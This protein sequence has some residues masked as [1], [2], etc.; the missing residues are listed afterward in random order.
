MAAGL[1]DGL[2]ECL[3]GELELGHQA[4]VALGLVHCVEVLAL[5]VLYQSDRSGL[6]VGHLVDESGD[7]VKTGRTGRSPAALS[8][9]DLVAVGGSWA[10]AYQQRLQ[11]AA[12][13]DR[14]GQFFQRCRIDTG[15][16]LERIWLQQVE[17]HVAD[18]GTLRRCLYGDIAQQRSKATAEPWTGVA[19]RVHG[20]ARSRRTTSPA[21][22]T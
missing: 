16:G 11:D 6:G 17:R 9:D 22:R 15:S 8:G 5:Q 12:E 21:S 10:R 7:L 19:P 1:A 20:W 13:P 18:S 14:L 2:A 4:V 3:L